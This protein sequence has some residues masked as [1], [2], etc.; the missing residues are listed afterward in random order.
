MQGYFWM[1]ENSWFWQLPHQIPVIFQYPP[2]PVKTFKMPLQKPQSLFKF[3]PKS[4]RHRDSLWIDDELENIIV[5]NGFR[6]RHQETSFFRELHGIQKTSRHFPPNPLVVK[7]SKEYCLQH[8][9]LVNAHFSSWPRELVQQSVLRPFN[10]AT[11][12]PTQNAQTPKKIQ[13]TVIPDYH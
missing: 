9:K 2:T 13:S 12:I 7:I 8:L 3:T 6:D 11:A 10:I 1:N 4:P 5:S